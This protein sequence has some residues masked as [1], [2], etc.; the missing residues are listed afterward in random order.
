ML[1]DKYK[2][3]FAHYIS[4]V[5]D[6]QDDNEIVPDYFV[7]NELRHWLNKRFFLDPPLTPKNNKKEEGIDLDQEINEKYMTLSKQI[8]V[9][10]YRYDSLVRKIVKDII[11]IYKQNG[12]GEY[13]L[14]EDIDE[15]E[16]E[17][18]LKDIFVTVELILVESKSDDGFLLN[19]DYYSDDD[20][21]ED[22]IIVKIIYNPE[23]KNQ[24]LYDMI[25]ELNEILAHELR[26]N[27]QK[28]KGLFDLKVEPNDDDEEEG[29]DY[30][31]KPEELDAQYYGFK[32][33]SKITNKPFKDLVINW[34]K[35]HKD[36]HQMDDNDSN[37]VIE[38][39]LD[40]KPKT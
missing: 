11:M 3:Q 26:H 5:A 30:Y 36:I 39:I 21:N 19:A 23:T 32:R 16:I 4:E 10:S 20:D 8:I 13:Y 24:V 14:P 22:V 35:T 7:E 2:I 37:R 28:N 31:T 38:K 15:N 33:M 17:Y 34:F 18:H 40:Y 25:G 12:E 1:N 6:E 27:Y 9:E 29:Y